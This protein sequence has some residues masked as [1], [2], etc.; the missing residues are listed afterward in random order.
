MLLI[1]F[2]SFFSN[3]FIKPT[4]SNLRKIQTFFL[5]KN[6]GG[7][8]HSASRFF[9][10]KEKERTVQEETYRSTSGGKKGLKENEEL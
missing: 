6:C 10:Y 8:P 2:L 7:V 1:E 5:K 9:I 3:K 4:N